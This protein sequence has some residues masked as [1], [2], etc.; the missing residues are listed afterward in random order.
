MSPSIVC[1]PWFLCCTEDGPVMSLPRESDKRRN[2]VRNVLEQLGQIA[3]LETGQAGRQLNIED[4]T[5]NES[6]TDSYVIGLID[7]LNYLGVIETTNDKTTI[8]ISSIQ[9]GYFIQSLILLLDTQ[10]PLIGEWSSKGVTTD[11]GHPFSK[12]VDF[13]KV[14]EQRRLEIDPESPPLRETVAAIG[15]IAQRRTSQD[16][17]HLLYWDKHAHMWQFVGGKSDLHDT[18]LR[19]TM[20]RELKEELECDALIEDV[21]IR[22]VEVGP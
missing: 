20:L 13:L 9:A 16:P 2:I 15:I 19:T 18:S 11:M 1:V 6:T 5:I 17:R 3:P 14:I 22:L 12:G 10:A 7:I 4:I 8:Q 21:H